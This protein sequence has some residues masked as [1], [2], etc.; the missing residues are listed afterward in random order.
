MNYE[1]SAYFDMDFLLAACL[2]DDEERKAVRNVMELKY[3]NQKQDDSDNNVSKASSTVSMKR[4]A[5]THSK[6]NQVRSK[7]ARVEEEKRPMNVIKKEAIEEVSILNEQEDVPVEASNS[8]E[9]KENEDRITFKCEEC[10]KPFVHRKKS[11][12][13]SNQIRTYQEKGRRI[14]PAVADNKSN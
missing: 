1:H 8:S 10:D 3:K 5:E 6:D 9:V 14:N 11:P 2:M 12:S 4:P 13:T 7:I